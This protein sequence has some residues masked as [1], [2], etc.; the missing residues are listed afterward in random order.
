MTDKIASTPTFVKNAYKKMHE[1]LEIVRGRLNRPLTL[2]EKVIYG[3]LDDPKNAELEAGKSYISVRPDRVALQDATAQMAILQFMLAKRS[4]AAVPVTV[5]CDHLIRAEVG[6]SQDLA[7]ANDENKE[8]YDFLSSSAEKYGFGFWKPGSGIIHQVVLEQYAFP[9]MM[10][11]G[12]DSHTPN[13]GGLGSFAS[14]VGGADAVDVMVDMPWDVLHPTIVGVHLKG[15]LKG[16]AAPKD[17]I[18]KLLDILT[19]AGGTNRVIEYFG[20]GC[21]SISTTGKGTICNMGAELGATTSIF[22]YDDRMDTYLK[23]TDRDDILEFIHENSELLAADAEVLANPD[24][25]YEKVITI[26]LSTLEPHVVGP[27]TPDLAAPVSKMEEHMKEGGW[28]TNLTSALI[29]SCTNS[30]YED[31]GRIAEMADQAIAAGAKLKMPLLI[32]PGSEQVRATIQRDGILD[33]LEKLGATV[34]ANACGPC[35]GQWKRHDIKEGEMNSI[36]NSFNRNFPKR[37]D[38]NPQTC[39]FIGSP[40]T[41]LAYAFHGRLDLNP[42]TTPIETD[43]GTFVFDSPK[44]VAEVP[45]KGFIDDVAGFQAPHADG[46]RIEVKVADD[47]NRLQLLSPFDAWSG[48]DLIDLPVLM[49]AKGKCTTDHISP[50]GPWLKF[51]GHLENISDNM[52]SGAI[53]AFTGEPG[54]GKDQLDGETKQ[55]NEVAKNYKA[56]GLGWVAVGDENYGE[57]SS[58]EHA[59]MCPRFLGA[60]AVITRSFARIHES[61]L[62]K[63]G[64]LA[65]TFVNKGDYDLIEEDDRISLVGLED[66]VPGQH[67]KGVIKHKDGST[68]EI[69]LKHSLNDDQI[70]WFKDG[71]ALNTLRKHQ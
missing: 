2:A 65:L 23:S 71:S 33:K 52:F 43:N 17:V 7:Q 62:K 63:Q 40:E 41:V 24:K 27:H 45:A 39:S 56:N 31:M 70:E 15:E 21:K 64:V 6:A 69:D 53:N 55:Y 50:A 57:G 34:L 46:G 35:I 3:H 9:G 19:V 13:A 30:S 28:P 61:N 38:G 11:I 49:K 51:R 26:D 12:T 66:L 60:R 48:K 36:I 18:L 10:M 58:R 14:G 47:S 25:Y 16:W 32:T 8:V 20:E 42:F 37:N 67:V 68:V 4:E 29:G 5:H 44:S 1:R 59:A 22:P 54:R